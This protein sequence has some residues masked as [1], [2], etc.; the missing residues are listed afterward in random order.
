MHHRK[1]QQGLHKIKSRLTLR[2]HH[3]VHQKKNKKNRR[4]VEINKKTMR[5]EKF[6]VK[7]KLK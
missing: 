7:L 5:K 4:E 2:V 6:S 3:W 1:V